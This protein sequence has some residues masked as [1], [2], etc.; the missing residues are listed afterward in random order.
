MRQPQR[1]TILAFCLCMLCE[2]RRLRYNDALSLTT[3]TH[4]PPDTHTHTTGIYRFADLVPHQEKDCIKR[5]I[6][7]ANAYLGCPEL[8]SFDFVYQHENL[9]CRYRGMCVCMCV[10]VVS[11][12]ASKAWSAHSAPDRGLAPQFGVVR[13]Y[14]GI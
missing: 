9:R 6:G 3:H 8:V 10:Y 13:V 1:H 5:K 11:T 2:V 12:S 7:C 14:I 4:T